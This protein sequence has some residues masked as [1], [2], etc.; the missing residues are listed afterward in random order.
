[1]PNKMNSQTQQKI[2]S[3]IGESCRKSDRSDLSSR[4]WTLS[5]ETLGTSFNLAASAGPSRPTARSV[6]L[7]RYSAALQRKGPMTG[8]GNQQRAIRRQEASDMARQETKL[9]FA[10]VATSLPSAWRSSSRGVPSISSWRPEQSSTSTTKSFHTPKVIA[11]P[12]SGH[13]DVGHRISF[14][15]LTSLGLRKLRQ[16]S[17]PSHLEGA[18]DINFRK[19]TTKKKTKDIT[20]PHTSSSM[21]MTSSG[22]CQ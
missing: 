22:A 19:G 13:R 1:M 10:P 21:A 2:W 5:K 8:I 20:M 6:W 7:F 11:M 14:S 3:L 17:R 16:S 15:P 9:K 18:A 12:E 4:P